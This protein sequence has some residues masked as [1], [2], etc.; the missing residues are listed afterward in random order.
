MARSSTKPGKKIKDASKEMSKT[1]GTPVRTKRQKTEEKNKR[2]HVSDEDVSGDESEAY[3]EEESETEDASSMD[4]DAID[5][6]DFGVST[7]ND[8]K[9]KRASVKRSPATPTPKKSRSNT[10]K[11]ASKSRTAEDEDEFDDLEDGQEIV[12]T[13]V[14]APKTGRGIIILAPLNSQSFNSPPPLLSTTWTNISEYI[15][16][17]QAT[18]RTRMQRSN[19]VRC[20]VALV[21]LA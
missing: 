8:K 4:S 1:K 18:S 20:Y 11:S 9:R 15:K 5:D 17:P 12:G 6:A 2:T 13:V 16:F 21:S 10:K 7:K 3:K 19:L 14:Q